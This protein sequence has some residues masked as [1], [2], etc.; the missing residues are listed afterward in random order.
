MDPYYSKYLKYKSK[1][2]ELK[3]MAG[4]SFFGLPTTESP[5][6]SDKQNPSPPK[7]T[8]PNTSLFNVKPT[9]PVDFGLP[10]STDVTPVSS[11]KKDLMTPDAPKK[12]SPVDFGLPRSTDVTP[13]SSPK[14]HHQLILVYQEVMM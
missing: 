4:G 11:P 12:S 14:N 3:K 6:K 10:R 5:K 1:Y 13:V 9:S 2:H 8:K 7:D